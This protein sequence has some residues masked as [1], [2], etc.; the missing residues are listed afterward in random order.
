MAQPSRRVRV[1]SSV[2][3]GR[4][5]WCRRLS[6]RPAPTIV[7]RAGVGRRLRC[8]T[9]TIGTGRPCPRQARPDRSSRAR[10]R[11]HEHPVQRVP[12][13]IARCRQRRMRCRSTSSRTVPMTQDADEEPA[14]PY[15][16]LVAYARLIDDHGWST[17]R[18]PAPAGTPPSLGRGSWCVDCVCHSTTG[19]TTSSATGQEL[20]GRVRRQRSPPRPQPRSRTMTMAQ[21]TISTSR[22]WMTR[23]R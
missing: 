1:V 15:V 14:G 9:P 17:R 21:E 18:P 11:D 20:A 13:A 2:A 16:V 4:R 19:Q 8:Q 3:A 23:C 5:R 12:S 22:A 6:R 7:A 10:S